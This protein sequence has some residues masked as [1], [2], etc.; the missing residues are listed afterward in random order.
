MLPLLLEMLYVVPTLNS[1]TKVESIHFQPHNIHH[2]PIA[3]GTD[4]SNATSAARFT[5]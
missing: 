3:T 5:E 1:G 2:L 4:T